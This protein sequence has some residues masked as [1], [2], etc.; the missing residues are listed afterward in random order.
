M[1]I[2]FLLFIIY[3]FTLLVNNEGIGHYQYVC[4]SVSNA[5]VQGKVKWIFCSI[6]NGNYTVSSSICDL[7]VRVGF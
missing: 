5:K 3:L 7:F 6:S 2:S 4:G 1:Y